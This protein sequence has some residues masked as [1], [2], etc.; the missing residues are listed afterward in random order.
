MANRECIK[1][2]LYTHETMCRECDA[3]LVELLRTQTKRRLNI[4]YLA[5]ANVY[6]IISLILRKHLG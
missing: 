4:K 3:R 5:L 6:T 2:S 1:K